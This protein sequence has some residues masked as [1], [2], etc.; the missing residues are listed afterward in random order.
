MGT[1]SATLTRDNT[2]IK[3]V[4]WSG[5]IVSTAGAQPRAESSQVA[6]TAAASYQAVGWLYAPVA[7]PS[8]ASIS[9]NWFDAAHT[10]L[11]TSSNTATLVAGTW[12]FFSLTATA[13]ASTAF[14]SVFFIM[15]GTPGAGYEL[16]GSC[17]RLIPSASVAT[18][19]P[20]AMTVIRS[21]N[22]VVKAQS[23]GT[24]VQLAN[25]AVIPL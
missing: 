24:V 22:G 11:S 4:D 25:P 2:Y 9:I 5:K 7:L 18:T 20:Q 6:V 14:A 16:Y 23:S 17:V 12:T 10:F 21:R 13:P 1:T 3:K 15:S 8:T 19:S